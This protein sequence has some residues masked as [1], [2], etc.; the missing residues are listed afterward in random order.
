MQNLPPSAEAF[1]V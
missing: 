1:S